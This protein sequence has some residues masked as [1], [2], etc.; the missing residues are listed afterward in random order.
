MYI[1]HAEWIVPEDE[2][3]SFLAWKTAEGAMQ[4]AKTGFVRRMLY[5]DRKTP[6]RYVFIAIWKTE[7]EA[8]AYGADPVF[9]A[10]SDAAHLTM[11]KTVVTITRLSE[12]DGQQ[13]AASGDAS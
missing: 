9:R 3:E 13:I 7:A 8:V 4:L 1:V 6:D 10:A 11:P 12:V 2:V 5:Q